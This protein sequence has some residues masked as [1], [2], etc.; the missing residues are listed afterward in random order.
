MKR[1]GR[2]TAVLL[3]LLMLAGTAQGEKAKKYKIRK[4]SDPLFGRLLVQLATAYEAP[5]P[6]DEEALEKILE[7]IRA[8]SEDDYDIARSIAEHWKAVYLDEAYELNIHRGEETAEELAETLPEEGVKHAFVVLGYELKDGKMQ[9]ELKGRLKAAVAAANARPES[10]LICS[11]GATGS[12]NPDNNTEAGLMKQYLVFR[13]GI[14]RERIITDTRAMSTLQNAE[15]TFAILRKR[16]IRS[17]TIVTS[18]YHQR[19]GQAVYNAM[20]AL[21][22]K[23]YGFSVQIVS[24]YCY[25]TKPSREAYKQDD[26]MAVRQIGDMLDLSKETKRKLNMP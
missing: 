13:G 7:S 6:G 22:E 25:E 21:Y 23:R 5:S 1:L 17:I 18:T 16:D 26:R 4:A 10:V 11:G 14:D 24:N 19:W 12:N 15:N 2:F 9:D 3:A 20:A 8:V